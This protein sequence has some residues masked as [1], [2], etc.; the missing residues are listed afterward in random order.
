VQGLAEVAFFQERIAATSTTF[1]GA[2]VELMSTGRVYQTD[3]ALFLVQYV[4]RK[5]HGLIIYIKYILF[6]W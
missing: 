4:Q 2:P 3:N 1:L 5:Q 6:C